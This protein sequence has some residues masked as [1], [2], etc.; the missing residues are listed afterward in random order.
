MS[1]RPKHH[2]NYN[3]DYLEKQAE[4]SKL[5][6]I[7]VSTYLTG[8][9]KNI[10]CEDVKNKQSTEADVLRDIIQKHYELLQTKH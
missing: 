9:I 2:K 10:F 7:R 4:K 8:K 1:E 3:K 5:F 6:K